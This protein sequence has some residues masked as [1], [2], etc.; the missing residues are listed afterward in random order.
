MYER[1]GGVAWATWYA[2]IG[3][4]PDEIFDL[5]N[6]HVA[7]R[8]LRF[9]GRQPRTEGK[10]PKPRLSKRGLAAS[11]GAPMLAK[12]GVQHLETEAKKARRQAKAAWKEAL[13]GYYRTWK[14]DPQCAKARTAT[15]PVAFRFG[16]VVP[17]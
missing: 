4:I 17:W 2:A 7:Q 8:I 11:Q 6:D 12:Q 9:A 5:A 13:A 3:D 10:H 16:H 15:L 1:F 14:W